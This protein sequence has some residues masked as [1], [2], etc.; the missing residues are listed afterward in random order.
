[1]EPSVNSDITY[2]SELPPP[3]A[4]ER[5]QVRIR[6]HREMDLRRRPLLLL[7]LVLL[8][9]LLPKSIGLVAAGQLRHPV[10]H[11]LGRYTLRYLGQP[12]CHSAIRTGQALHHHEVPAQP[13]LDLAQFPVVSSKI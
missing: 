4:L 9:Q 11:H 1:M 5:P 6:Q 3:A 12:P 7:A 8:G 10:G 13:L 2:S